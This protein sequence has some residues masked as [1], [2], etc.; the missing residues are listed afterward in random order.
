[1]FNKNVLV[2]YHDD[3]YCNNFAEK[4]K[5]EGFN[6]CAISNLGNKLS[7]TDIVKKQKKFYA[8]LIIL[9]VWFGIPK[10]EEKIK[11]FSNKDI[12]YLSGK[13]E[14][15]YDYNNY[16]QVTPDLLKS[17]NN[18]LVEMVNKALN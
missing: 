10:I 18:D 15:N 17:D 9:D 6:V 4:L 8:D 14:D 12:I 2:L 13:T 1:M 16:L 7:M 5:A 3:L 11:E